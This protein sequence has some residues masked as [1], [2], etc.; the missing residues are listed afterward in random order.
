MFCKNCGTKLDDGA[1]FCTSCGWK[2]PEVAPVMGTVPV[3][4]PQP[5]RN[6]SA[7]CINA[8]KLILV[9]AGIHLLVTLVFDLTP[10][11]FKPFWKC[12]QSLSFILL[13]FAIKVIVSR[14]TQNTSTIHVN[15]DKLI[16]VFAGI[17]LLVTPVL[18]NTIYM[19]QSFLKLVQSLSFILLLFAMKNKTLKIIGIIIIIIPILLYLYDIFYRIYTA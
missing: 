3:A 12:I 6:L 2:V 10:Y 16:L 8:D 15:T 14:S 7:T 1:K 17:Y 18:Y 9:F 13:L 4:T 5:V 11:Q 19:L